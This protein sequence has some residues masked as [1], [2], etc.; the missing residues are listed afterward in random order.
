MDRVTTAALQLKGKNHIKLHNR[1]I[2]TDSHF[3][4]CKATKIVVQ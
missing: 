4:S 1:K 3:F 2:V